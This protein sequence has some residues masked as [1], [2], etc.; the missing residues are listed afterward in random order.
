MSAMN[1]Q[2]GPAPKVCTKTSVLKEPLAQTSLRPTLP[3]SAFSPGT[4]RDSAGRRGAPVRSVS[5]ELSPGGTGMRSD[6]MS[7]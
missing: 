7:C 3:L 2:L 6:R 5:A 1:L 4:S